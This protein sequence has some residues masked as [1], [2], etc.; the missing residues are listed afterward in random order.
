M[1]LIGH[2]LTPSSLILMNSLPYG[3]QVHCLLNT[4]LLLTHSE[5]SAMNIMMIFAWDEI[6]Q[7]I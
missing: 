6:C 7:K 1:G 3:L 2:Y 5:G 4:V